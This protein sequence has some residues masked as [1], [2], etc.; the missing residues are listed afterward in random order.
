MS[1]ASTKAY[2]FITGEIPHWCRD[3]Q[4]NMAESAQG[5]S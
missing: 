3:S 2:R 1:F 4:M 5:P